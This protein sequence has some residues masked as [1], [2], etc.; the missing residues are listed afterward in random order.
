MQVRRLKIAN[1][2]GVREATILLPKHG[3]LIGDNN[4]GKTTLLEALDLVLGP[5]RLNRQPPI[6]EHDFFEGKYIAK[7]AD[8]VGDEFADGQGPAVADEAAANIAGASA[9]T[10]QA[11]VEEASQIEIEVTIT[12]LTEEQK[13]KFGDYTEFWDAAADTL[14]DQPN[15]AGVDAESIAEALRVTF[16]GWYDPEEDDFEGKTYFTRSL[17]ESDKPEQF[18]KKDKQICGFLYLRSLRTGTRAL[19]LKRGSL[20][21]IILRL[22]EVRPRMWEDTISTLAG[23]SV[24]SDPALGISGVRSSMR[25]RIQIRTST[26][27][28]A[29]VLCVSGTGCGNFPSL[30]SLRMVAMAKPVSRTTSA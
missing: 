24:A 28:K 19:S 23:Y 20:L 13:G 4:T 1:F 29:T 8:A 30:M 10:A 17:S 7:N 6:D 16:L 12:G 21:D 9:G 26:L 11:G 27:T 14:Y 25:F 18:S 3:V 22:K 5:D 15:P 2:R